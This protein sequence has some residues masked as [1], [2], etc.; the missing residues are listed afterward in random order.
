LHSDANGHFF[1]ICHMHLS[2]HNN[3]R[4]ALKVYQTLWPR[5]H[6]AV[7]RRY[8]LILNEMQADQA[9]SVRFIEMAAN[10]ILNFFL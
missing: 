6:A 8:D 1:Y 3:L 9:G 2:F 10:G 7:S 5:T 4:N